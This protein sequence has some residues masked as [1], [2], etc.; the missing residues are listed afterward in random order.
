[1]TEELSS[2]S[3]NQLQKLLQYAVQVDPASV[4]SKVFQ[5]IGQCSAL[6]Y[7]Y[8]FCY[9]TDIHLFDSVFDMMV[10]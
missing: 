3:R 1:M 8:L 6:L 7:I 10:V 5:H 2:L 9:F 4:L